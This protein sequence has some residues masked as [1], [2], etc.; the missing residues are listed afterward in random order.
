M[1]HFV[2]V[3]LPAPNIRLSLVTMRYRAGFPPVS[4]AGRFQASPQTGGTPVPRDWF[5]LDRRS[6]FHVFRLDYRAQRSSI[7]ARIV[8]NN[9]PER[10]SQPW[11][12]Q[13]KSSSSPANRE[14]T[15]TTS[16]SRPPWPRPWSFK[17]ARSSSGSSINT[18][19]PPM[20]PT[21]QPAPDAPAFSTS[22]VTARMGCRLIRKRVKCRTKDA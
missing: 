15:N 4:G 20:S 22:L 10:E 6:S 11:D 2:S 3:V 12:T 1:L 19:T 16:T 21:L 5:F 9:Q 8:I 18:F 7:Y 17:R 14:P 13:P